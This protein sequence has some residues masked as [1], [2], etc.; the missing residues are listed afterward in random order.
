MKVSFK[1]HCP[2]PGAPVSRC[3]A[4]GAAR[5]GLTSGSTCALGVAAGEARR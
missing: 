2:T 5:K 4:P 1:K 3:V